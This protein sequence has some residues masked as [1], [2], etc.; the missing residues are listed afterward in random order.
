MSQPALSLP[1][2]F[3]SGH[4]VYEQIAVKPGT[5]DIEEGFIRFAGLILSTVVPL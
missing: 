1:V 5:L 2:P 3:F 4:A